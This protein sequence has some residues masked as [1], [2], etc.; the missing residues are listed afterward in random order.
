M[1]EVRVTRRGGA[2]VEVAIEG[3]ADYAEP[4]EDIVC[5]GVSAITFGAANAV[6]AL[7]GLDP[8]KAMGQSGYLH[9]QLPANPL[10]GTP[11][12]RLR[13]AA[14]LLEGMIIAL[15]AL[16]EG[17]PAHVAVID[18]EA[19]EGSH[20][21]AERRLRRDV[22]VRSGPAVLRSKEGRRQHQKRP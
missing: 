12:E 18:P 16:A 13:D 14:L 19:P 9:F 1:I 2:L 5:A 15:K 11:P 17:Y 21:I 20:S 7:S 22:P 10:P 8:V 3:H 6:V 4:G